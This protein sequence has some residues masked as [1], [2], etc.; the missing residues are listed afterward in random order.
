MRVRVRVRPSRTVLSVSNLPVVSQSALAA[1]EAAARSAEE[2]VARALP[3][4][5]QLR[6]EHQAA[7]RTRTRVRK[8]L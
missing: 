7:V 1:K 5:V 3:A 2:H 8:E 4:H 6:G